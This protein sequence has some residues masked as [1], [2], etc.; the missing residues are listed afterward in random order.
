MKWNIFPRVIIPWTPNSFIYNLKTFNHFLRLNI[1]V[2]HKWADPIQIQ[3]MEFR[4]SPHSKTKQFASFTTEYSINRPFY[5]STD[6]TV[7]SGLV[8]TRR[9]AVVRGIECRCN[10]LHLL[11]LKRASRIN[12]SSSRASAPKE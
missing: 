3:S 11:S 1:C 2:R 9:Q 12:S 5:L 8:D 6:V 10:P 4:S 7:R